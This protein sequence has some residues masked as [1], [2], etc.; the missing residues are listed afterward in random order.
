MFFFKHQTFY[1]NRSHINWYIHFVCI[2][3][4]I[5]H[6]KARFKLFRIFWSRDERNR[7]KNLFSSAKQIRQLHVW[8]RFKIFRIYMKF[9]CTAPKKVFF[10]QNCFSSMPWNFRKLLIVFNAMET[11]AFNYSFLTFLFFFQFFG[12]NLNFFNI[13]FKFFS[14]SNV[15]FLEFL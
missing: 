7:K 4:H 6:V 1:R 15:F 11:V 5:L 3:N 10:R 12:K 13:F 9:Q 8:D 2:D 14:F